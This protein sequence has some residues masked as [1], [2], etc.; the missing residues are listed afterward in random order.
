MRAGAA[1]GL[2]YPWVKDG[3]LDL[4]GQR[5]FLGQAACCGGIPLAWVPQRSLH[6]SMS[7]GSARTGGGKYQGEELEM[8]E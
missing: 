4:W 3:V 6:L 1:Q 8:K 5:G 2:K 7:K